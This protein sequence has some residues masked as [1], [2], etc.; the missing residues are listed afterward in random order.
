MGRRR[1]QATARRYIGR[2]ARGD[3]AQALALA[4]FEHAQQGI[5]AG[6]VRGGVTTGGFGNLSPRR[7]S[8]AAPKRDDSQHLAAG[9]H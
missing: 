8:L 7:R 1:A 3:M 2:V 6:H 4:A 9:P 5:V